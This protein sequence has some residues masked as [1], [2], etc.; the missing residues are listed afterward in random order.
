MGTLNFVTAML[1]LQ[2]VGSW[3]SKVDSVART[4]SVY[5]SSQRTPLKPVPAR[6]KVRSKAVAEPKEGVGS[7]MQQIARQPGAEPPANLVS[8]PPPMIGRVTGMSTLT[9]Q[10]L[11]FCAPTSAFHGQKLN[12]DVHADHMIVL[13]H[14][15]TWLQV[16]ASRSA[17]MCQH[18]LTAWHSR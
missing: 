5:R 13:G 2:P 11:C 10:G 16:D 1:N 12:S 7:A 8:F 9:V 6:R 15:I 14:H 17:T 4:E 3:G 18:P